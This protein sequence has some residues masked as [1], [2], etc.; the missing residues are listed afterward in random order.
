MAWWGKLLGGTFG[1]LSAGPLGAI[2]GIAASHT[3]AAGWIRLSDPPDEEPTDPAHAQRVFFDA[4]FPAL[5]YLAK[6]DG[7]V[8]PNEIAFAKAVMDRMALSAS[9]RAA[10]IQLFNHGK[11]PDFLIAPTLANFRPIGKDRRSLRRLFVELLLQAAWMDGP[12][13]SRERNALKRICVHL[14]VGPFEL[15]RLEAQARAAYAATDNASQCSADEADSRPRKTGAVSLA[16]AYSLLG[17][18]A[19]ATDEDVKRAYRRLMNRYHPDKLAC[20][21]SS[22]DTRSA[23]QRAQQIRGAYDRIRNARRS[24]HATPTS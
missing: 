16:H 8:S 12:P 3:M 18:S 7:L 11:N 21:E 22:E 17:I 10:A 14:G 20:R 23:T 5:G 19:L 1:F 15:G 24:R 9:Q 4:L 6:A 2:I 13:V